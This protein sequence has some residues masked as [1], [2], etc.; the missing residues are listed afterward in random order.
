MFFELAQFLKFFIIS[1][2]TWMIAALLSGLLMHNR[3]LRMLFLTLAVLLFMFFTN[4]W[5]YAE[6]NYRSFGT[7]PQSTMS[8][9]KTYEVAIVMGGFSNFNIQTGTLNFI[10]D[11]A[12]RLWD[13]VKLYKDGRVKRL[14]ITGDPSIQIREDNADT[15]DRFL[16]YMKTMGV[17][18]SAIILEKK[19]LNTQQNARFT[20]EILNRQHIPLSECVIITNAS[21]MGRA[22]RCFS[23]FGKEPAY[24]AVSCPLRPTGFSHRSLYPR[25]STAV[26]WESMLNESVG[27][28]AYALAGYL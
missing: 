15:S 24:Y 9:D 6:F 8:K 17:P 27:S 20:H 18:D 13:A 21:H 14:L 26:E 16:D 10:G 5:I 7:R 22:L 23:K 1:P 3:K 28:L 25:W 2:I 12:P 11:R 4:P 19:A